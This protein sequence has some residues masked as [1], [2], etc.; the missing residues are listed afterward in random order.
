MNNRIRTERKEIKKISNENQN[1]NSSDSSL[2]N[3]SY[4]I[5]SS[6]SSLPPKC[7]S[8]ELSF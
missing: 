4:E 6:I 1:T 8:W 3:V 2:E 5:V 7:S